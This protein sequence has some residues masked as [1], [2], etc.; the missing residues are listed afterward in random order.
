MRATESSSA[1]SGMSVLVP[2]RLTDHLDFWARRIPPVGKS[3]PYSLA[4]T[5]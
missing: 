5:N 1:E 2:I 4:K 3:I